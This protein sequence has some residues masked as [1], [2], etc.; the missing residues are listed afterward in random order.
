MF[1]SHTAGHDFDKPQKENGVRSAKAVVPGR[2]FA[3][4]YSPRD[5]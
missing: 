5:S 3:D 1:T 2:Q 4:K